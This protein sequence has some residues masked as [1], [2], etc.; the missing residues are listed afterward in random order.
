MAAPVGG[1]GVGAWGVLLA[2]LSGC[3]VANAPVGEDA[4]Q[5]P[6]GPGPESAPTSPPAPAPS[7]QRPP[8]LPVPMGWCAGWVQLTEPEEE[9]AQPEILAHLVNGRVVLAGTGI[10][11]SPCAYVTKH[12]ANLEESELPAPS[13]VQI[14]ERESG[15]EL[16]LAV[17]LTGGSLPDKPGTSLI[18][19]DALRVGP[20][21]SGYLSVRDAKGSPLLWMATDRDLESLRRPPDL[22]L[23]RGEHAAGSEWEC[24]TWAAYAIDVIEGENRHVLPY[25][26]SLALTGRTLFHGG[27]LRDVNVDRCVNTS[28][29]TAWLAMTWTRAPEEPSRAG[30]R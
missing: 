20:H 12:A 4:S 17:S 7:A 21:P 29:A 15:R 23:A 1:R 14:R 5:E 28:M 11:P 3:G 26:R 22:E 24:G 10:P 30:A 19:E 2:W 8:P 16:V 25:G 18:V 27:L 13:W 6:A 9:V